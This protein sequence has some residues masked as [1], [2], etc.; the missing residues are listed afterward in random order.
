MVIKSNFI[1][2]YIKDQGLLVDKATGNY[3]HLNDSALF[4]VKS[5]KEGISTKSA[6]CKLMADTYDI[7]TT[8]A[9]QDVTDII[10]Q[11]YSMGIIE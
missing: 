3:Y 6:L 11:L 4:I 8:T 7:D 9:L 5:I 2:N 10:E 1:L